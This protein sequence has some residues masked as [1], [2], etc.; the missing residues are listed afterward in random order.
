M[1]TRWDKWLIVGLLV[2]SALGFWIVYGSNANDTRKMAVIEM[3]GQVR[4][5]VPLIP[6]HKQEI[7]VPPYTGIIEVDGERIRV[8]NDDTPR[9]IGVNTGWIS[10]APQTIVVVPYRLVVRITQQHA[11]LDDITR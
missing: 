1:L 9:Q 5:T 7:T 3:H 11:D 10:R 2:C 4:H 6:G 8:I